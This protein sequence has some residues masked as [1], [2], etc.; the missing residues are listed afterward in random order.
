M[1]SCG[2]DWL[3]WSTDV[4]YTRR[5]F[6]AYQKD[7][8]LCLIKTA[9]NGVLA[10]VCVVGRKMLI[11]ANEADAAEESERQRLA[12]AAAAAA[13]GDDAAAADGAP[14]A[15]ASLEEKKAQ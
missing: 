5:H 1:L 4:E 2:V 10:G 13:A 12:A 9:S 3:C 8:A 11:K 15:V 14:A 7:A 6:S